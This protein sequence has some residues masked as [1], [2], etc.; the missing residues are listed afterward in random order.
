MKNPVAYVAISNPEPRARIVDDLQRQ[1][2][3]VI[4]HPTG[5]HVLA[6]LADVL[7]G[8]TRELPG[9]IVI[10]AH[11]RGCTGKSIA[12]GLAALGVEIAVE[13]VDDLHVQRPPDVRSSASFASA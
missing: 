8:D 9:K 12:S 6:A 4:E 2:W 11:A 13:L 5:F 1:G 7:D 10:D 3:T